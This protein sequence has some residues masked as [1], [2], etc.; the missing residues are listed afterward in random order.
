MNK[1]WEADL[2]ININKCEF[3]VQEIIFLELL[4]FIEELKMNSRKIQAVVKWSIL[5]NL[6]QIQS[7]IDFCN[8]Y[9][10]FIKNF[11]KIVH[12][13]IQLTQK[14]IIFEWNEVCQTAFNHMK[15]CMTETFILR[16]FDQ[17]CNFI[18]EID[19]FNYVN[20]KVLSQYNDENVL[21]LIIFYSKNMSFAECNYKI[22]DKKLL[23]IIQAFEHWWFELKLINISIK[24]FI[25]H[26]AL[27]SLMKDKKLSQWQMRWVQKLADFNFKIMYQSDKQNIK[28]DALTCQADFVPRNLDNKC[29]QY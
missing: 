12:S 18:L 9:Q 7:F 2:Q 5:N 27:I 8:F 1:L 15:R 21:H 23:I 10:R 26:Q 29:I 14:K 6:T 4:I 19:S 28:I 25:N 22:Y 20:D 11:S 17:T 3:H 24:M 13:I 16:H